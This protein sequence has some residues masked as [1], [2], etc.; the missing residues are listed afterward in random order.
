ML[1][2]FGWD[3]SDEAKMQASFRVGRAHFRQFLDLQ[4]VSQVLGYHRCGLASLT[5]RVL[6]FELPKPRKVVM[7]NWEARRLSQGQIVYAALDVLITGQV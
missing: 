4:C 3:G 2:G 1:C 7:S 6:G 5:A